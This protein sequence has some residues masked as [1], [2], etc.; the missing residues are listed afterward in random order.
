[1]KSVRSAPCP[2]FTCHLLPPRA[3]YTAAS[4]GKCPLKRHLVV[5]LSALSGDQDDKKVLAQIVHGT[6]NGIL[7]ASIYIIRVGFYVCALLYFR[8][9]GRLRWRAGRR[10]YAHM[11]GV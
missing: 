8:W 10:E 5:V 6:C 1:M 7:Y 11:Q 2:V 4:L 9:L 3:I